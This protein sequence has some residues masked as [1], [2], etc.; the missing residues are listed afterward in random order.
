MADTW[1]R[2]Y[3]P[4]TTGEVIARQS[5]LQKL[6][7][8]VVNYN[9]QKKKAVIIYG[10]SGSGKTCSV[11]ALAHDLNYE[12]LE[13][14]A[15]D[16]RNKEAIEHLIGGATKQRSLFSV[17]KVIL[18]DEIDGLSGTKD[19]G[20]IAALISVIKESKFPVICTATDPYDQ[21]LNQLRKECELIEYQTLAYTSI[22]NCLK[23]ICE[24]EKVQF[25]EMLLKSLARKADGDLRAGINDLQ[26]LTH[27]TKMLRKEDLDLISDRNKTE[28]M[29]NALMKVFKTTDLETSKTAFENVAE[30]VDEI[31]LWLDE[32]LPKEYVHP[33]DL[34]RAYHYLSR[35]DVYRG[36]IRRWQYWR[37]TVYI[38]VLLSSGIAL[39]K[40]EKYKGFVQYGPTKR[41]LK[42]WQVNMKYAKR[43][44][45][46]AKI[47]AKTHSSSRRVIQDT[48]LY[49][50]VMMKK[51][52]SYCDA[53]T[54]EFDLDQEEVGWI[55]S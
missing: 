16:F 3:Q 41:I 25:D 1:I 17:S 50:Q 7:D 31:F 34:A 51:S 2:K 11:Y 14:N 33:E 43:K 10:G 52:K 5:S 39:S 22:F 28:T 30:D 27:A 54:K 42:L 4:K 49:V 21:K 48:L 45:I 44:A 6:K 36:R 32:N 29:F 37:F 47:A 19:R 23:A 53:F 55:M 26:M 9:T 13:I 40:S 20:G 8:F 35:A 24:K 18:V 12:I 46:A 38:L 15:S